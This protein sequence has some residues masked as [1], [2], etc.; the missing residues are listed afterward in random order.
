[1]QLTLKQ[2]YFTKVMACTGDMLEEHLKSACVHKAHI[3][4][5]SSQM[6]YFVKMRGK[7]VEPF[8]YY[9]HGMSLGLKCVFF[10]GGIFHLFNVSS[11]GFETII[12]LTPL[13][14]GV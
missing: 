7:A 8:P 14:K 5:R 3:F 2:I 1:M 4:V 10:K 6:Q 13:P 12:F 9:S 11:S